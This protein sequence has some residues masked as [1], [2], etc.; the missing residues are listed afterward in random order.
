MRIFLTGAT[1]YIGGAV[2]DAVLRAGNQVTALVRDPENAERVSKR[3]IQPV[4]GDLS[5][6]ASYA[7]A[8]EVCDGIVHTALESSARRPRVDRQAIDTLMDAARRRAPSGQPRFFVYTSGV[9]VLGST[10]TPATED[11][12]LAPTPFSAWRPQHEQVVL[13]AGG[14]GRLRTAGVRP[15]IVYGGGPGRRPGPPREAR[16]R[17]VRAVRRGAEP[18]P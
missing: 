6:P 1:G 18:P 10:P 16:D 14:D 7:P 13:D 5:K 9:W 11:A 8:A 3:G 12:P 15:G 4:L 2:L 17:R